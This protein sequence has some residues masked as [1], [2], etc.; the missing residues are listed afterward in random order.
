MGTG[1][2]GTK[3]TV[4]EKGQMAVDC[5]E[6]AKEPDQPRC[7]GTGH[8][9]QEVDGHDDY[10]GHGDQNRFV[11]E[12]PATIPSGDCGHG[13]GGG[14][15]EYCDGFDHFL[16]LFNLYSFTWLFIFLA[17]PFS[18]TYYA[19]RCHLVARKTAKY[20]EICKFLCK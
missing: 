4:R 16:L 9:W 8:S 2:G 12:R 10:N 7:T 18:L 5:P 1:I 11:S 20:K 14:S 6:Q 13:D 17:K 15:D 19:R 3:R